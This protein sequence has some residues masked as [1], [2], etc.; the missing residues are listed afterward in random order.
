MQQPRETVPVA[1]ARRQASR[2]D[3]R[4]KVEWLHRHPRHDHHQG[5]GSGRWIT[6][7]R[8]PGLQLLVYE[9]PTT[10][11][12]CSSTEDEDR[13]KA[14]RRS[15]PEDHKLPQLRHQEQKEGKLRTC[16]HREHGRNACLVWHAI[17]QNR[18]CIRR[19]N[20]VGQHNWSQEITVHCC[21]CVPGRRNKAKAHG[22][23][24]MK[25]LAK[26]ELST[27]SPRT[28][29]SE[30]VDGRSWNEAVGRESM[31]VTTR[32]SSE[33]EKSPCL[34]LLPSS[35]C[36]LSEVSSTPNKHRHRC[37]RRRFNQHSSTVRRF[38]KQ[39]F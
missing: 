10:E 38:P 28:L 36:R 19:E 16:S 33:K 4:A 7:N 17:S 11:E 27:W 21:T 32:R 39:A 30:G 12:S 26:R 6:D 5:E 18:E 37:N 1:R 25:D 23:L 13:P 9:V 29:L 3:W 31:A 22:D 35:S 20:C 24:Q 14:S 2:L 8:V 15:W 34:G